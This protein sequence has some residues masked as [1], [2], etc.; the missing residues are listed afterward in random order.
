MNSAQYGGLLLDL[1][2]LGAVVVHAY[3][4]CRGISWAA[5]GKLE[6]NRYQVPL[7]AT[8]IYHDEDTWQVGHQAA[9]RWLFLYWI[10]VLSVACVLV[11]STFW[12]LCLPVKSVA[13]ILG[14]I[15]LWIVT[16]ILTRIGARAATDHINNRPAER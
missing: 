8:A 7:S 12:H 14:L 4:I 3:G 16:I 2:I 5:T 13:L 11:A 9:R 10:V 1:F 15:G 6:H